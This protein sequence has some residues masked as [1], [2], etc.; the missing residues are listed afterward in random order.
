MNPRP[1]FYSF[2]KE[3]NKREPKRTLK[4]INKEIA[5]LEKQLSDKKTEKYV[6]EELKNNLINLQGHWNRILEL[7][8]SK[9]L[10]D[11]TIINDEFP[12][13]CSLDEIDMDAWIEACFDNLRDKGIEVEV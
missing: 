2:D 3:C 5:D 8:E 10:K 13:E 6:L 11:K 12:F 7:L 9:H 4:G 1:P